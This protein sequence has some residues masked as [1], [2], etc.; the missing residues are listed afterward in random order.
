MKRMSIAE[1]LTKDTFECINREFRMSTLS[2][3]SRNVLLCKI[4][5]VTPQ[6]VLDERCV[7]SI[8]Y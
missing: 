3:D 7:T 6:D 4:N 5:S 2:K 1:L 8:Y